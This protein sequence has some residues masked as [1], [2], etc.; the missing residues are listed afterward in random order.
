M[1]NKGKACTVGGEVNW[2][3]HCGKH[4]AAAKSRQ[5]CPTLCDPIDGSPPGSPVPG[6]F[7]ARVLEWVASD[8]S[9]QTVWRLL[10]K[11]KIGLPY[12]PGSPLLGIFPKKTKHWFKKIPLHCSVIYD[13]QDSKVCDNVD[14]PRGYCAKWNESDKDKYRMIS[15]ICENWKAKQ[16]KQTGSQTG[17]CQR[18]RE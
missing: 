17:A 11:L 7:Q 4:Y 18:G 13:S 1:W 5:S 2:Y 9:G 3:S 14:R 6:N 16:V 12:D 8:F 15:L 10:K